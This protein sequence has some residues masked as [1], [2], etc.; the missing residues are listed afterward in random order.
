MVHGN[1]K[2]Q[3]REFLSKHRFLTLPWNRSETI[4]APKSLAFSLHFL[5][6]WDQN[7][8]IS[9]SSNIKKVCGKI[10]S[11]STPNT[12]ITQKTFLLFMQCPFWAADINLNLLVKIMSTETFL[13]A[14]LESMKSGKC[15][16]QTI[17]ENLV[18]RKNLLKYMIVYG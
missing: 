15:Y 5:F 1:K 14:A 2:K 17:I 12:R 11:I 3:S 16:F 4:H 8:F 7:P 6:R 10:L 9:L 18:L 13:K